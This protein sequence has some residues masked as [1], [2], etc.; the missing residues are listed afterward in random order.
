MVI[1][2]VRAEDFKYS[3]FFNVLKQKFG[4]NLNAKKRGLELAGVLNE[5]ILTKLWRFIMFKNTL[6][7]LLAAITVST[8]FAQLGQV[9]QSRAENRPVTLS[10]DAQTGTWASGGRLIPVTEAA[11]DVLGRCLIFS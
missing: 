2:N 1:S 8:S 9:Q 5:R 4:R 7:F 6:F 3:L 11:F 10:Y